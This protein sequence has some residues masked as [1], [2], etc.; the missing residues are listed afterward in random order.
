MSHIKYKL[1]HDQYFI[2]LII[3]STPISLFH[4]LHIYFSYSS[5][6]RS[7]N[8]RLSFSAGICLFLYSQLRHYFIMCVR[9]VIKVVV[10]KVVVVTVAIVVVSSPYQI[11]FLKL[12]R[13]IV[14]CIIIMLKSQDER[15]PGLLRSHKHFLRGAQHFI[16]LNSIYYLFNGGQCTPCSCRSTCA[17]VNYFHLAFTFARLKR[18][19]HCTALGIPFSIAT[20]I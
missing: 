17:I 7:S 11:L 1:L 2:R 16:S 6:L 19:K 18:K 15:K 9:L 5:L 12:H 4:A 8:L 20:M 14:E 13:N 10:A 3:H